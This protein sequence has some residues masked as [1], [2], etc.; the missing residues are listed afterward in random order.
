MNLCKKIITLS[1]I[2]GGLLLVGCSK[3]EKTTEESIINPEYTSLMSL[4]IYPN[5]TSSKYSQTEYTYNIMEYKNTNE[6]KVVGI[7]I[8][9]NMELS[10]N[11]SDDESLKVRG[12]F[13]KL[14]Q[15][16]ATNEYDSY[17]DI[18]SS[19]LVVYE[20]GEMSYSWVNS[21]DM[22]CREIVELEKIILPHY[23]TNIPICG[24]EPNYITML[25]Y[26]KY[27][28]ETKTVDTKKVEYTLIYGTMNNNIIPNTMDSDDEIIVNK[29]INGDNYAVHLRKTDENSRKLLDLYEKFLNNDVTII[30][31]EN[32]K[33]VDLIICTGASETNFDTT[34]QYQEIIELDNIVT[35]FFE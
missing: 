20:G 10:V 32:P 6:I 9:N 4:T 7:N 18:K 11:L 28:D 3:T 27:S 31:N 30:N 5:E 25:E 16:E 29:S 17:D 19:E 23:M 35:S 34:H 21:N 12:I 8:D 22:Y 1:L 13:E 33:P 26:V 24:N 2:I 15:H 14:C